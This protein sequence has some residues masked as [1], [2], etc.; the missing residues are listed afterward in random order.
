MPTTVKT[1]IASDDIGVHALF[2]TKILEVKYSQQTQA[3][4]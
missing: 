3:S 4:Q 2:L 1:I